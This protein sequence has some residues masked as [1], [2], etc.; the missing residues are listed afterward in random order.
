MSTEIPTEMDLRTTIRGCAGMPNPIQ[1]S[2]RTMTD[3]P[4]LLRSRTRAARAPMPTFLHDAAAVE[5]RQR[6]GEINR[7]FRHI[8]IV[9]G[10]PDIWGRQWQAAETVADSDLIAFTGKNYDLIV[11]AMSL[12]WSNDPVGQLIQC[13]RVLKPDGIVIACL[14]GGETLYELRSAIA[15]AELLLRGGASP[16]VA[17]MGDIRDLGGLLQRAGLALPVADRMRITASYGSSRELMFDL[18]AMGETN[19]LAR[20][21]RKFATKALFEET[22]SSYL[23]SFGLPDGRIPAT[24]DL[25]FLT[26]WAPSENQQRALKPGSA[27]ARLSDA[28]STVERKL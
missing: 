25:I 23:S 18:R 19:A 3:S 24:F 28:L 12:H 27:A 9:T 21:S 8:A 14:L 11:H 10:W 22:E 16:R 20:R 13:R 15:T 2:D 5:L 6:I 4:A 7:D 26:G 17:P 1:L